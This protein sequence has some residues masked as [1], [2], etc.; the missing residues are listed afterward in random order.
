MLFDFK[1][2]NSFEAAICIYLQK[3]GSEKLRRRSIFIQSFPDCYETDKQMNSVK[4]FQDLAV[5]VR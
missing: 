4:F 1:D 3:K 2:Q 5:V